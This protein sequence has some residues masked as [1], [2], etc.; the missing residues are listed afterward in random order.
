MVGPGSGVKVMRRFVEEPRAV[1]AVVVVLA[2]WFV[3]GGY[4]TAYAYVHTAGT[5][6]AAPEKAGFTTVTAAW[7]L[8]TL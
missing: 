3:L 6:L 5:I 7:S 8:L 4:I 1:D 2:T